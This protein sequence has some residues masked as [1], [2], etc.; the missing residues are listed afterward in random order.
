MMN[1]HLRNPKHLIQTPLAC[2]LK[3]CIKYITMLMIYLTNYFVFFG[4]KSISFIP[5]MV[6]R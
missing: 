1:L 3:L 5:I 4:Y 2:I 6:W